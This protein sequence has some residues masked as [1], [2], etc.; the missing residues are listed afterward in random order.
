M[1]VKLT[2]YRY[3]AEDPLL[4]GGGSHNKFWRPRPAVGVDMSNSTTM[5]YSEEHDPIS[6]WFWCRANPAVGKTIQKHLQPDAGG[7]IRTH[8][9]LRE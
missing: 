4:V 9:L 1:I 8:E 6:Y 5:R 7:G 2:F 3:A